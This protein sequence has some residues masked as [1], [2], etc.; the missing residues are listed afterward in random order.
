MLLKFP[1]ETRLLNPNETNLLEC[2]ENPF[3]TN[4]L[5]K[6]LAYIIYFILYLLS[7][8]DQWMRS[9]LTQEHKLCLKILR[10]YA[11]SCKLECSVSANNRVRILCGEHC[12]VLFNWLLAR[13]P[14]KRTNYVLLVPVQ[15]QGFISA[16][17]RPWLYP[18]F[19]L[20]LKTAGLQKGQKT[21]VKKKSFCH[22]C[23]VGFMEDNANNFT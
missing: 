13:D 12:S 17:V 1:N 18:H 4:L 23:P 6:V 11:A 3:S 15:H 2:S 5:Y 8:F 10:T 7:S 19:S 22:S 20:A 16:F 14:H 9:A 21:C